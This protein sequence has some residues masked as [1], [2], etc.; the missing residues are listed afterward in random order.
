MPVKVR[1]RAPIGLFATT[2]FLRKLG[3]LTGLDPEPFIEREKHTTIK[4]IWDLWRS[5]TQDFFGTANFAVVANETYTRGIR[6]F[7][8]DEMGLPCNFAVARRAGVP[9]Q[10]GHAGERA[11][12]RAPQERRRVSGVDALHL[13]AGLEDRRHRVVRGHGLVPGRDEPKS[14]IPPNRH[15]GKVPESEIPKLVAITNGGFK[16]K[17]GMHG[18]KLGDDVYVPPLPNAAST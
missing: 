15:I 4:P 8:E 7:L 16:R 14:D 13:P 17:H 18:M 5:V 2:N 10:A 11:R 6:H 12:L 3:E 1:L 9:G